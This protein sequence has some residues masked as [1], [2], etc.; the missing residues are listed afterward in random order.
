MTISVT[1]E[2]LRRAG[3]SGLRVVGDLHGDAEGFAASIAGAESEDLFVLQLG[4]L[5]DHGPDSVAVLRMMFSLLDARRGCFL[6]GNHDHK[7]RRALAGASVRMEA[8]GLARTLQQ[9]E[10]APD[11]A[12]LSAR[13]MEEIARAPAWLV[14]GN[15]GFVHGAW[16]EAMRHALPPPDAG[17]RRPN[18]PVSRALFG[19][20]TGRLRADGSPE[21]IY[22]W[23]DRLPPDFQ[24]YCGHDNRSTDGRPVTQQGQWGGSAVFLDTGAGKG[25]HLS[26]MDLRMKD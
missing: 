7:L 23:V 9:I 2:A 22:R 16:H 13:A 17:T 3:F 26:W 15:R 20:V 21:R 18:G 1:P 12:A 25:G 11:G 6:L 10:A 8:D 4:D 5:T 24:V 19:E 14:S